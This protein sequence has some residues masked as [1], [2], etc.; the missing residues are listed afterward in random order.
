MSAVT[1]AVPG[2]ASGERDR[3]ALDGRR[4]GEPPGGRPVPAS[5]PPE[6]GPSRTATTIWSS[7]VATSAPDGGLD[8]G[9]HHRLV[10]DVG[11]ETGSTTS[12]PGRHGMPW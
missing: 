6:P 9:G 8:Q 10:L 11:A 2:L 1:G 3:A 4:L 7:S 5:R 12:W